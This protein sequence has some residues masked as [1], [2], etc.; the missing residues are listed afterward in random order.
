MFSLQWCCALVCT[1]HLRIC[2]TTAHRDVT[3]ISSFTCCR[4][5]WAMATAFVNL[6]KLSYS[7][8]MPLNGYD[9][10]RL[11]MLQHVVVPWLR[12]SARQSYPEPQ[13]PAI[14]SFAVSGTIY[15]STSNATGVR[16][17]V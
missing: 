9:C 1:M 6:L 3:G 11:V 13:L 12:C 2:D 4:Q 16:Y 14:T 8:I 7:R 10:H 17:T 5:L 15:C